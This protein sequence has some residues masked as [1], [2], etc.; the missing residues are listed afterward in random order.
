M[1]VSLSG[2]A[3]P[4]SPVE[5]LLGRWMLAPP[6]LSPLLSGSVTGLPQAGNWAFPVLGSLLESRLRENGFGVGECNVLLWQDVK[7][8]CRR[9]CGNSRS[10]KS[11]A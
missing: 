3:A 7:P 1:V 9:R 8:P 2:P 10:R 4:G 6:G 5:F 11:K